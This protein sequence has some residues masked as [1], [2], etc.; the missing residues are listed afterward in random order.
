MMKSRVEIKLQAKAGLMSNYGLALGSTILYMVVGSVLA[1]VGFGV[2]AVILAGPLFSFVAW[3]VLCIY[4]GQPCSIAEAASRSVEE[5]GRKIGGYLWMELWIFLWSLVFVIPGIVKTY[6]YAMTPYIL[7]DMPDIPAKEALKLSMRM[8]RGHKAELF[9]FHL[10]FV[11]WAILSSFTFGL[12]ALLYVG[13]YMQIA[14]AGFY[15]EVK[16][17]AVR[18]GILV[19]VQEPYMAY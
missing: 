19:S 6:S 13:P 1:T 18:R 12:L 7:T 9:V 15:D 5:I 17:D 16:Q 14:T 10:S 8:M 4:R 11:G 2:A 3:A